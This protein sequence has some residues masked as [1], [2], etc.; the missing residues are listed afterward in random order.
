MDVEFF[1]NGAEPVSQG[2]D[3]DAEFITDLLIE[4]PFGKQGEDFLFAR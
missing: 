2:V 4:I 3:A 1:V